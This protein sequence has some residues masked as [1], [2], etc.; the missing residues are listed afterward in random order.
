M[1]LLTLVVIAGIGVYQLRAWQRK[2][3]HDHVLNS[4]G[5]IQ[6][7]TKE[8]AEYNVDLSNCEAEVDLAHVNGFFPMVT[9]TVAPGTTDDDLAGL[10]SM[11][12]LRELNLAECPITDAGMDAVARF[13]NLKTLNLEGTQVTGAGIAK[14]G[15]LKNLKFLDLS[16]LHMDQS[17]IEKL[18]TLDNL[19]ELHL[20]NTGLTD[21]QVAPLAG[22]KALRMLDLGRNPLT[23]AALE[24]IGQIVTLTDLRLDETQVTSAG[25]A[26][27]TELGQLRLLS[28]NR[29]RVDNRGLKHLEMLASLEQIDHDGSG[30]TQ[31]GVERLKKLQSER[32]AQVGR[33]KVEKGGADTAFVGFAGRD[34]SGQSVRGGLEIATT[35]EEARASGPTAAGVVTQIHWNGRIGTYTHSRLPLGEYAVFLRMGDFYDI[36]WIRVDGSQRQVRKDYVVNPTNAATVEIT[37][38]DNV[39]ILTFFPLQRYE[40]GKTNEDFP[41]AMGIPVA[42]T[43]GKVII[44]LMPKTYR[45]GAGNQEST[46]TVRTG[47]RVQVNLAE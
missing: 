23:D 32:S 36:R 46:L 27:L 11:P 1:T 40:G 24:P 13:T 2:W 43:D 17:G 28:L 38:L 3:A 34:T 19:E 9:L 44:R 26:R 35:A 4:G 10:G 33:F 16:G 30:I 15:A 22:M 45:F 14:L 12:L 18:A 37:V 31:A 47:E 7:L 5:V 29:T 20:D 42:V 25:L 39:N 8:R 21:A 41:V 6:R